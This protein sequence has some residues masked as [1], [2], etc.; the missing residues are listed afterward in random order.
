MIK[1]L[2]VAYAFIVCQGD[3]LALTNLKLNKLVYFTQVSRF[4]KEVWNFSMMR[5]R[6]GN[7]VPLSPQSI[8]SSNALAKA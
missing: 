2:D 4:G 1:S 5:L 3:N 8:M 6:R 7:T